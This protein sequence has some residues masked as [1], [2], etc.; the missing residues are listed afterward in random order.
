LVITNADDPD[1]ADRLL[2][3]LARTIA[4][5]GNNSATLARGTVVVVLNPDHADVLYQ[6]G[7]DRAPIQQALWRL[8]TNPKTLVERMHMGSL[9]PTDTDPDELVHAGGSPESARLR[10]SARVNAAVTAGDRAARPAIA[11]DPDDPAATLAVPA[12]ETD[13]RPLGTGSL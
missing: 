9:S 6:A 4:S 2:E 1:S 13:G 5:L 8:A 11:L 10:G 7:H 3:L 12:T